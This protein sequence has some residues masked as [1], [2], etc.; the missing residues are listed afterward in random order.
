MKKIEII[1]VGKLR[2]KYL[3]EAYSEYNKRLKSYAKLETIEIEDERILAK[4][5]IKEE[6]KAKNIEGQKILAKLKDDAFVIA[7]TLD[8]QMQSSEQFAKYMDEIYI[9]RVNHIA[10]IIGGSVGLSEDIIKRA[11][12]KLSFSKMTFPHQ[13]FRI[14][15]IEQ[16]YR[17]CK[18]SAN[19]TYHK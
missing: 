8:G 3:I 13:L 12:L 16:I 18:I 6:E 19:E 17:A 11:N 10:F 4:A 2:E 9:N 1:C 14:I 5:S 7:M 15:L